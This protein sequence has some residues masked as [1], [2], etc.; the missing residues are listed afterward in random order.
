MIREVM[1]I[2]LIG[3]N[4]GGSG[5]TTVACNLAVAFA[6]D[7]KEVCIVDADKQGSSSNW[8]TER[9]AGNKEPAITVVQKYDNISKTLESL[10][11][12]YEIV[13]VDVAGR[14]SREMITAAGVADILIC[15]SQ[16]SQ[17]DLD[18]LGE[19]QQQLVRI[20]D[21]NEGLRVYIYQTM[22]T[23][24]VKVM[25]R[26]RADFQAYL[27]EYPD[28]IPLK[29]VGR[30]RKIYRDVFADGISVLE[31]DNAAAAEEITSLYKEVFHG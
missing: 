1:M 9:E 24:N 30:Y 11:D 27:S 8:V 3:S 6:R 31:A 23:T 5:K 21:L 13:I 12:K 14:N 20:R 2:I 4:K 16:C 10:A 7:G 19:L 26:E 15:P 28:L 17:L 25:E 18:T 29:S 22:A